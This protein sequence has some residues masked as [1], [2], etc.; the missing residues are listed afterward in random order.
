MQHNHHSLLASRNNYQQYNRDICETSGSIRMY[1][2]YQR[3]SVNNVN[4]R[5]Q[6]NLYIFWSSWQPNICSGTS[7][8]SFLY[9]QNC[10]PGMWVGNVF[11][12]VCI[13]EAI[14]SQTQWTTSWTSPATI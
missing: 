7:T 1:H 8:L 6:Y 11:T 12:E 4:Y 10:A 14:H 5:Q 13:A 9:A 3:K 2:N